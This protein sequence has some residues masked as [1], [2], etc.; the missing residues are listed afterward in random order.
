MG[1]RSVAGGALQRGA[2]LHISALGRHP[3]GFRLNTQVRDDKDQPAHDMRVMEHV[4]DDRISQ[5]FNML[6]PT[7][8]P[9]TA[10]AMAAVGLRTCWRTRS[11]GGRRRLAS[12]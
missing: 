10:L 5:R 7:Q 1:L 2:S 11:A 9:A 4:V 6:L 8:F 12:T 3:G